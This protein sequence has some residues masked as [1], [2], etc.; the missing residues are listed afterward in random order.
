MQQV[1]SG[2]G[3]RGL[4]WHRGPL[5]D[6]SL[7]SGEGPDALGDSGNNRVAGWVGTEL[8]LG[9]SFS[10]PDRAVCV[11]GLVLGFFAWQ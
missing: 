1:A 8:F 11:S 9:T 2:E 5:E 4:P 6:P 7:Q 10:Q 3:D